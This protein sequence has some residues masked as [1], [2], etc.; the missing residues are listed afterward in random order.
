MSQE[1][2]KRRIS[3]LEESHETLEDSLNKLNTTIA[4]LN[5][6]VETMAKREEK[7]QQFMDRTILFVVGGIISAFIAWV[8][9][10]GLGQ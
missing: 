8:V 9:R 6:T 5:Q 7:R 4:L 1:D 2:F 10:G 3:R